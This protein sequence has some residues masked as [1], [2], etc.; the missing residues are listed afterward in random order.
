MYIKI[1][2]TRKA[3]IVISGDSI[4][5]VE[6]IIK[7]LRSMVEA[8]M[9]IDPLTNIFVPRNLPDKNTINANP[10]KINISNVI[11]ILYHHLLDVIMCLST[12]IET[13]KC[14]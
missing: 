14:T 11:K 6:S 7:Y 4:M 1:T 5:P 13:I 12:K 10:I 2:E 3:I 9:E 8:S